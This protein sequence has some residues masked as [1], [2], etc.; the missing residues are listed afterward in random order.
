M[1]GPPGYAGAAAPATNS[2][3]GKV[4]RVSRTTKALA[5]LLISLLCSAVV[6]GG[7]LATATNSSAA[8]DLSVVV[9]QSEDRATITWVSAVNPPEGWFVGRDGKDSS[10]YGAWSSTV[11]AGLRSWTFN[12]LVR[13]D[14]Y[15]L[16]VKSSVGAGSVSIVAGA[17]QPS[18]TAPTLDPAAPASPTPQPTSP[19]PASPTPTLSAPSTAP[20][21]ELPDGTGWL[22]GVATRE[23]GNGSDPAKYFGDWR[24]SK[25]EIGQTW[26]HTPDVWGINPSVQ[27]S[28]AGFNG[29]MSLSFTPGPDWKG[30]QGWR[31]YA[32]IARGDMDAW[33]RAAAQ[34]TRRLRAGKGTT[35]VSPFYEYNGDWMTW[36]VSRTTQGYSDFRNAWAR[37][38]AIWR[39]EFPEVTLVLPAAC[40]RDVPAAMMPASNTY[41]VV[42]C[43]IYNAWPWREDGAP[44]MRLL[45]AG[46]QRALAAGK[47]LGITEWA[48]SANPRTAGGGGD[49]PGFISAMHEWM[50][51][52]AGSG[53]GQLVFETF[54]NIDG[55][56]LD[57]ILLRYNGAGGAVSGSQS[58]TATRYRELWNH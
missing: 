29:P 16:T 8:P 48:N 33:W 53:P 25:V 24:G 40:S 46:R 57:H 13:G 32:A 30:M 43:T 41:D 34:N 49:A 7:V 17:P 1:G 52:N 45:E 38:A 37:V 58:R 18:A 14:R 19:Q 36:S 11:S 2:P 42:G 35:Y 51:K 55:Y 47:P 50:R 39:Q 10:G 27:N 28:W 15:T 44:T 26:P 31:S 20:G 23:H 22:S 5:R 9:V 54:F 3:D 6:A 4:P 56:S 12:H 21:I